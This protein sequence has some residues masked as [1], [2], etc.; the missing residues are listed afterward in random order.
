MIILSDSV[1]C[2]HRKIRINFR[3]VVKA[4]DND[5]S[6]AGKRTESFKNFK[7]KKNQ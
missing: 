6:Y 2:K 1:D 3:D 5:K 4:P 7:R